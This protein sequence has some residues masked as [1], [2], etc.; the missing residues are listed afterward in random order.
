MNGCDCCKN[1]GLVAETI[2]TGRLNLPQQNFLT[3]ITART[4]N[5]KIVMATQKYI[6]KEEV[7]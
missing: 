3:N 6:A 1:A 2:C 5:T 4:P 7:P